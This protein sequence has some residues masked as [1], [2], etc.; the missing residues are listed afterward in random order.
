[1]EYRKIV[2]VEFKDLTREVLEK[3]WEWLSDPQIKD[4]TAAPDLDKNSSV[5]WFEGL[6]DRKDYLI[7][8]ICYNSKPL[9]VVGLRNIT[10]KDAEVF[11]YI[12]EKEY[13]GKTVGVQAL[14][15]AVYYGKLLNLESVYSVILKKNLSSYKL[16]RRLSFVN[17]GDKDENNITMRLH[18]DTDSR[19]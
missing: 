1:M 13:W 18:L 2:E 10:G 9:G 14:E 5:K 11:G 16:H 6:K 12:G 8:V 7:K 4:L 3:T 17:E 15:F 19:P